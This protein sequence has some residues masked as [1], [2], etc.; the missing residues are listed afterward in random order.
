MNL[1]IIK[2]NIFYW[3]NWHKDIG[4]KLKNI[5]NIDIQWRHKFIWIYEWIH[6]FIYAYT[7]CNT[8]QVIRKI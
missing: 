6:K 1:T 2:I 3:L 8:Y 5:Y 4:H 7:Q